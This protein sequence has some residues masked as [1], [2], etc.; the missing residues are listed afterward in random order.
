MYSDLFKYVFVCV[1]AQ[2][3][4]SQLLERLQHIRLGFLGE[5][6]H[7]VIRIHLL[8][9]QPQPNN[10]TSTN[11]H[12]SL[13]AQ[14]AVLSAI[15]FDPNTVDTSHIYTHDEENP[16]RVYLEDW[17]LTTDTIEALQGLP[18]WNAAVRLFFNDMPLT[19]SECA[20]LAEYIPVSY[21]EWLVRD[22]SEA[23]LEAICG[24]IEARRKGLGLP[25][26]RVSVLD[27]EEDGK[28]WGEHVYIGSDWY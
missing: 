14:L 26:L 6:S 2:V 16:V 22:V 5:Q 15:Q 11:T 28:E 10:P 9:P 1:R 4:Q 21:C 24:G 3:D 13:S 18:H 25:R 27:Y 8:C 7:E 19:P 17:P 23:Q 12:T 20:K